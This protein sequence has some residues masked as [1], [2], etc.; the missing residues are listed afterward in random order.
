MRADRTG[1]AGV[2][3]RVFA[4]GILI[5]FLVIGAT[6]P[7]AGSAKERLDNDPASFTESA[8][9]GTNGPGGRGI[10]GAAC[11]SPGATPSAL[12][13]GNPP[14]DSHSHGPHN[15]TTSPGD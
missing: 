4:S 1:G 7:L 2:M 14:L 15:E 9:G 3:R 10:S 11:T 6:T 13:P 5:G 12:S 8:G